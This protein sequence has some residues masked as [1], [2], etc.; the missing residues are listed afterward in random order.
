MRPVIPA[1]ARGA[2]VLAVLFVVGVLLLPAPAPAQSGPVLSPITGH[3]YEAVAVAGGITWPE[4]RDAA[5]A[6]TFQGQQGYLVTL[7]SA[8]ENYWVTRT[9]PAAD[10]GIYLLGGFRPDAAS[11]WRW[12]TG[13]PW[14]YTNW[15]PG[16]PGPNETALAFAGGGRWLDTGGND[17]RA[18]YVVE[19]GTQPPPLP[20]GTV[21]NAANGHWYQRVNVSPGLLW[22]EAYA[23]SAGRSFM[24]VPGHLATISS[25]DE[26]TFI[27]ENLV[28][29]VPG[30][31][32]IGGFRQPET[33]AASA[34]WRWVTGEPWGAYFNW[35]PGQ[36][37]NAGG[38]QNK[39]RFRPDG[40]WQ[41]E[42][43]PL[44]NGY[45]LEYEPAIPPPTGPVWFGVP[46]NQ[47]VPA[48]YDLCAADFDGDGNPDVAVRSGDSVGVLYGG[49]DGTL[50]APAFY[51]IG[52]LSQTQWSQVTAG[53][54]DSDGR[55]DLVVS[56]AGDN[57]LVIR[58][59]QG[60]RSFGIA[61]RYTVGQFPT[62]VTAADFNGDQHVDL[63][64]ANGSS[65]NLCVLLNRGD[66]T[67]APAV[68]YAGTAN[69]TRITHG[70]FNR[71]G[72]IDLA[73]AH[74]SPGRVLTYFGDGTG[75]FTNGKSYA[76][77][78]G[79]T[80]SA[81]IVTG[82]FNGDRLTD[83]A[84]ANT[85]DHQVVLLFGDGNGEFALSTNFATFTS[86]HI[87]GAADA[88][89]DGDTDLLIPNIGRDVFT[90]LRNNGIGVF[91]PPYSYPSGGLNTRHL[92]TAD[93][94][95]DGRPDVVTSSQPSN[96]VSVSLNL[97]AVSGPAAPS[98]LT[99][100]AAAATRIDLTWN[101]NS[102]S[103]TLFEIE[104]KTGSG[105]FA[106]LASVAAGV[107]THSDVTV[108][109]GTAYVYRV[110][111][112]NA[113]GQSAYSNEAAATTPVSPPAPPSG[114]TLLQV[115]QTRVILGWSDQSSSQTHFEI[116]RKLGSGGEPFALIGAVGA[117]S[118]VYND[119][120]VTAD[121]A[122]VYRVRAVN[123]VS[124]S[125]YSDELA[126]RTLPTPP[127]APVELV[128]TGGAARIELAWQDRS[129][130][131]SGFKI[132]RKSLAGEFFVIG[133]AP[134][135]A[136][137]FA[138]T[139]VQTGR[140]YTYRV[141]SSNGGG[142]S[143]PS[144]EASAAPQPAVLTLQSLTVEPTRVRG[145]KPATGTVTLS[146]P[147]PAGGTTVPLRSSSAKAAVPAEVT[148][149][150]GQASASFPITTGKVRRIVRATITA[151]LGDVTK[152]ARLTVT[153]R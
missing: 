45:V 17:R 91:D 136:T 142:D 101:D 119:T 65:G 150:A 36:P 20:P 129:D 27:L 133:T 84:V 140:T 44:F 121:T 41:D 124:A 96:T 19:Y 75:R 118:T 79:G 141:R 38:T 120:T 60:G 108:A 144:N 76:V 64:V 83:L 153:R 61:T 2:P 30:D 55:P 39:L 137:S 80:F 70:D 28:K 94:N 139:E 97:T 25:A 5:A 14:E 51:G 4:A 26:N 52:S 125:G 151:T 63:A 105:A 53:D 106:P 24:G 88:D 95:R 72:R 90:L 132:E 98:N 12:I 128:A 57:A 111:S 68:F 43:N 9:F 16:E 74:Q 109:A 107:T 59:N 37:D 56:S 92:A 47:S 81:Q 48:P 77:G 100:R 32:W 85:S 89:G 114:L 18:G 35:L 116:E 21:F 49:G 66:G 82:D 115:R 138:D 122:Y 148:V 147:A 54:I 134:A 78:G 87:M 104:R 102:S 10:G 143:E 127:A 113:D 146:G 112:G 8:D 34:G 22:W 69:P 103:E 3:H 99:A 11:P 58:L 42:D 86:P 71:D 117:G 152:T 50:T 15:I 93:F 23:G 110:R 126:V 29:A 135:G 123:A 131:E 145:E 73:M 1:L 149:P 31:Y 130:N 67:L 33:A 40:R 13:E 6:R 62:G 7:T 46:A